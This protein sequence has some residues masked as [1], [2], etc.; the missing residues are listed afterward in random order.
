LISILANI[1]LTV[2]DLVRVID[3][4]DTSPLYII[5]ILM[6]CQTIA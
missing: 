1:Q 4:I 5:P 3:G 6:K 2:F